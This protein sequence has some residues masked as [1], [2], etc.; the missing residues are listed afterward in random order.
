MRRITGSRER[1]AYIPAATSK[2]IATAHEP[3]LVQNS[4]RRASQ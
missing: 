3:R 2:E 4:L 1:P